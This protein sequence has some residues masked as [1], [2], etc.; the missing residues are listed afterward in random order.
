[1]AV[2]TGT[3]MDTDMTAVETALT[4]A[5][6]TPSDANIAAVETA[7]TTVETNAKDS[8]IT[9]SDG[10]G[11]IS[12]NIVNVAQDFRSDVRHVRLTV[13][14]TD[15]TLRSKRLTR[16]EARHVTGPRAAWA[17]Y[18]LAPTTD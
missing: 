12:N 3:Q 6:T 16:I 10:K 11:R 4:T 1:M 9:A 17:A 18:R 2:R 8:V 5:I 15:A 14:S 13:P 7:L